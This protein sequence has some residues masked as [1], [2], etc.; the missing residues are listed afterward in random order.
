[1]R[2]INGPETLLTYLWIWN[3]LQVHRR[4]LDPKYPHGH[5]FIDATSVKFA[6]T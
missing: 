2:S 4:E 1:M 3:S 5:G 6:G